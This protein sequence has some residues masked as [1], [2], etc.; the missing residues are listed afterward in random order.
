MWKPADAALEASYVV[1]QSQTLNDHCCASA[2]DD[3]LD[4]IEHH[5][6]GD[7]DDGD[8]DGEQ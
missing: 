4:Q 3:Q 7:G 8:G 2:C 1:E 5:G 6:A